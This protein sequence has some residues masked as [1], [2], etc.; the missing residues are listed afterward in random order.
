MSTRTHGGD[1]GGER[2]ISGVDQPLRFS[3][4]RAD[5]H[6]EG[7]IAVPAVDDRPAVDRDDVAD[8]QRTF[9]WD[10]VDDLVVDGSADHCRVAVIAEEVRRCPTGA[11]HVAG[12]SVE[13]QRGDTGSRS[14]ADRLMHLG[15]HAAGGAHLSKLVG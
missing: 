6:G 14:G 7:R 2:S 10:A 13:M 11:Q 4:D 1:G 15:D 9:V 8:L 3:F 12:N 5:A